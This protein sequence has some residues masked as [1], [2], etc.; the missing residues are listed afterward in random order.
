MP[1]GPTP[2]SLDGHV[3]LSG[4]WGPTKSVEAGKPNLLPWAAAKLKERF[5]NNM[6]DI[7][8][9]HCLPWGPTFDVP[10]T[11]KFIQTPKTIIVLTEDVF[12]YRQIHMD[13]RA[14]PKDA[15]PTWMGHSVGRWEGDT[16]VVDTTGFNDKSWTPMPYPHTEKLH[17]VERIRRPDLGHIEIETTVEDPD[18]YAAPW[19][20]KVA[21]TLLPSEEIGEYICAENNQYIGHD[22]GK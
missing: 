8:T 18:T 16:F 3:D 19:T 4:V 10:V 6:K 14:H 17:L 11:F 22:V 5:E 2:K 1:T 21:S 7:P 12:S 13:G 9:S 20:F 15:D